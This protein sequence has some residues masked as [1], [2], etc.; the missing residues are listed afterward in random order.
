MHCYGTYVLA[1]RSVEAASR[2]HR[3]VTTKRVTSFTRSD[4]S[5]SS[6]ADNHMDG[7]M[8]YGQSSCHHRRLLLLLSPTAG[9]LI[10]DQ[11]QVLLVGCPPL[12]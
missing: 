5:D 12:L 7:K 1:V 4:M 6:A 2:P 9:T 11:K 8:P 3:E 10:P